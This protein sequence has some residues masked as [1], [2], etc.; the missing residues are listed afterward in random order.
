M[1]ILDGTAPS[2]HVIRVPPCNGIT[3][4]YVGFDHISTTTESPT[5]PHPPKIGAPFVIATGAAAILFCIR[6]YVESRLPTNIGYRRKIR[7]SR[8]MRGRFPVG[9][10]RRGLGIR[11]R[12]GL[13]RS[14]SKDSSKISG[15]IKF[16]NRMFFKG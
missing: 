7:V 15:K 9:G 2:A 12:K 5:H 6:V 1:S 11:L 8:S 13:D 4:G 14:L 10:Y 3:C 16:S